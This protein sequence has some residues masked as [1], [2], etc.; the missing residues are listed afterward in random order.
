MKRRKTLLEK[1]EELYNGNNFRIINEGN[2]IIFEIAGFTTLDLAEAVALM[3]RLDIDNDDKVWNLPMTIF[4]KNVFPEK[5][6][7][8]LSG[9]DSEWITLEHYS[10]SWFNCMFDFC[11]K[12]SSDIT[13]SVESA[14]S[15]G[16]VRKYFVNQLNLLRIY[17]WA[18]SKGFTR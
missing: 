18:I 5:S 12:W 9:G 14:K 7:Y 17:E 3:I 2:Q 10:D 1:E 13:N 4:D 8:W 16:D 11:S 15:L 6:L